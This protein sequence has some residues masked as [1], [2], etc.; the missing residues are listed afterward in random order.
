MPAPAGRE[1]R[2]DLTFRCRK[3]VKKRKNQVFSGPL[4]EGEPELGRVDAQVAA[5]GTEDGWGDVI[6]F[7]KRRN[8]GPLRGAVRKPPVIE[9]AD[10]RD[11]AL[12]MPEN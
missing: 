4:P 3:R 9:F 2:A 6:R 7:L 8:R 11:G 10:E 1:N 5:N 12:D